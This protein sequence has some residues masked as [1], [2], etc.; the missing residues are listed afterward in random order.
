MPKRG[1][2]LLAVFKKQNK[3]KSKNGIGK[4]VCIWGTW[5][6]QWL[7]IFSGCG[8]EVLGLSPTWGSSQG[9]CFS[10]CL[11]LGFSLVSLM[12]K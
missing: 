3:T 11:C 7:S 5:V 2:S 1:K 12:N 9:T 10:C 6:A 4:G 8:P